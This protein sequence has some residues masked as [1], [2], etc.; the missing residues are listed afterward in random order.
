MTTRNEPILLL[1]P[2]IKGLNPHTA[3]NEV[4]PVIFPASNSREIKVRADG[5]TIRAGGTTSLSFSTTFSPNIILDRCVTLEYDLTVVVKSGVE[6]DGTTFHQT[7]D[8]L[9]SDICLQQFPLQRCTKNLTITMN[10]NSKTLNSSAVIN[11][12]AMYQEKWYDEATSYGCPTQSDQYNNTMSA[13]RSG[14]NGAV[15]KSP[16]SQFATPLFGGGRHSRASFVPTS[17]VRSTSDVANDTL[18]IT[19]H[20]SEVIIHPFTSGFL[21][22]DILANVNAFRLEMN[23]TSVNTVPAGADP[24][25]AL[26]PALQTG[27]IG[28][29]QVGMIR[30]ASGPCAPRFVS[31]QLTADLQ[32]YLLFRSYQPSVSIP[33]KMK[34]HFMD[35]IVKPFSL[36]DVAVGADGSFTTGQIIYQ[37]VPN[38]LLLY[39]R[40]SGDF[41]SARDAN[42]FG[43][44]TKLQIRTEQDQGG[45]SNATQSQLWQM[46]KRNGSQQTFSEFTTHQGS[47][48]M[49]NLANSD[50]GGYIAGARE[51]ITMDISGTFTNTC[52][53]GFDA[54]G[55]VRNNGTIHGE[56]KWSLYVVSFTQGYM[57]LEPNLLNLTLGIGATD[58]AEAVDKGL[59]ATTYDDKTVEQGAGFWKDVHRGMKKAIRFTSNMQKIFADPIKQIAPE[60]APAIDTM[61]KGTDVL[62]KLTGAG[63]KLGGGSQLGGKNY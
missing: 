61:V 21:E 2:A 13:G 26:K 10:S 35:P 51:P 63:V 4:E 60:Y 27:L 33:P 32:P 24:D 39:I 45:L 7:L 5:G 37:H 6:A 14:A 22:R 56:T 52:Y 53:D 34:F 1:S 59:S 44:I 20:I 23:F 40:K 18:T 9:S 38:Y 42:A 57:E 36:S 41:N 30:D 25:R 48:I 3:E 11:A 49:V 43:S 31:C 17:C 55:L 62:K 58:V 12:M 16:D 54:T 29:V 19:Y 15:F 46:S 28:A 47:V 8:P 50:I